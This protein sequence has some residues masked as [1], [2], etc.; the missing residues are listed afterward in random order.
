[1]RLDGRRRHRAQRKIDQAR[2]LLGPDSH[3]LV[4]G[5]FVGRL[6][7]PVEEFEIGAVCED[8]QFVAT[9][10]AWC[11]VGELVGR[12]NGEDLRSIPEWTPPSRMLK[13][14]LSHGGGLSK[15]SLETRR[16]M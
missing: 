7:E 3:R 13:L 2:F 16:T 15:S 10:L 9:W 1:M 14:S 6:V 11:V 12:E 5:I 4:L 8:D